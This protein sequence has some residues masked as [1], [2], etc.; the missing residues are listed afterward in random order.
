[1]SN[2]LVNLARRGAGVSGASLLPPS[3][4]SVFAPSAQGVGALQGEGRGDTSSAE[5]PST[6]SSV[7]A[8]N[9]SPAASPP[10]T[11]LASIARA[12]PLSSAAEAPAPTQR[13]IDPI[14][15]PGA[16]VD[17]A[18]RHHAASPV[19]VAPADPVPTQRATAPTHDM[20]E[21]VAESRA[22]PPAGTEE[23]R[24]T[25]L[26]RPAAS[27]P[28]TTG[29]YKRIVQQASL[30]VSAPA[31]ATSIARAPATLPRISGPSAAIVGASR[32]TTP[33]LLVPQ[34]APSPASSI[35]MPMA[36][37]TTHIEVRIGRIEVR[38]LNE[39]R[40]ARAGATPRRA[41]KLSLQDYLE[42]R[43]RGRS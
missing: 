13:A 24:P 1:M 39:A 40:P 7:V 18:L 31:V 28:P 26:P 5:P 43:S 30:H 21:R 27:L 37:E 35:P 32:V 38:A 4:E 36:G 33:A 2:F 25:T 11:A 10:G 29:K 22:S 20:I 9:V 34:H 15:A 41:P 8:S 42:Q 19:H 14:P 6:A 16:N 3:P 17:P 23:R 12:V